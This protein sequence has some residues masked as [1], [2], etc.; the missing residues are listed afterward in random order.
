LYPGVT[1]FLNI[2]PGAD[3]PFHD[4]AVSQCTDPCGAFTTVVPDEMFVDHFD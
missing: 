3:L 1:Y 2:L 4:T